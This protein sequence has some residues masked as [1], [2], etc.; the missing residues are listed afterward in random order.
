MSEFIDGKA[1]VSEKVAAEKLK[2]YHALL[3]KLIR[4]VD[5]KSPKVKVYEICKKAGEKC[6]PK[7]SY[8]TKRIYTPVLEYLQKH[9]KKMKPWDILTQNLHNLQ[10]FSDLHGY[11]TLVYQ[12]DKYSVIAALDSSHK[13]SLMFV[14]IKN[15]EDPDEYQ[16]VH[17]CIEAYSKVVS[18]K[19]ICGNCGAPKAKSC[20]CLSARFCSDACKLEMWP[21]HKAFCKSQ[22]QKSIQKLGKGAAE[23]DDDITSPMARLEVEGGPD[24]PMAK[25]SKPARLEVEGGP[26]EPMAKSSTPVLD[27]D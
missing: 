21:A 3:Q 7:Q 8:E 2:P 27:V 1:S 24:E 15:P 20:L 19:G 16:W 9:P 5:L 10:G 26:D 4:E 13:D 14:V 22:R 6:K 17:L 12:H 18:F 25:S 23:G 11:P